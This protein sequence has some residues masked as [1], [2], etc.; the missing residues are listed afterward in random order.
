[1]FLL[2]NPPVAAAPMC[3]D[4][5]VMVGLVSGL[6]GGSFP[7]TEGRSGLGAPLPSVPMSTHLPLGAPEVWA[8]GWGARHE[9]VTWVRQLRTRGKTFKR[10]GSVITVRVGALS[11]HRSPVAKWGG[12]ERGNRR[13][14]PN[15]FG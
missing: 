11:R 7:A 6:G 12:A 1:M 9:V 8:D 15:V 4:A 3:A 5:A 13:T 10:E 2:G 14:P